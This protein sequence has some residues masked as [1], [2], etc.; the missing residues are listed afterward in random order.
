MQSSAVGFLQFAVTP[1]IRPPVH[2]M[3][4]VA[5]VK[6]QNKLHRERLLRPYCR[7]VHAASALDYHVTLTFD[8]LTSILAR[9]VAVMDYW[10]ICTNFGVGRSSRFPF[11]SVD[12]GQANTQ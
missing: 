4:S 6:S 9:L 12:T 8:L 7:P 2:F 1:S 3:V 10:L 11:Y 5:A